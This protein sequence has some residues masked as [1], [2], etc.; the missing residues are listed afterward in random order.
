MLLSALGIRTIER[1]STSV[2]RAFLSCDHP[3]VSLGWSHYSSIMYDSVVTRQQ[4][5]QPFPPDSPMARRLKN[6]ERDT[7][8]TW[9][10]ATSNKDSPENTAHNKNFAPLQ[11]SLHSAPLRAALLT[12]SGSQRAIN[13][14]TPLRSAP[15]ISP[16][17][18]TTGSRKCSSTTA[19]SEKNRD[20]DSN[21][22]VASDSTEK[23][24]SEI[25]TKR[26]KAKAHAATTER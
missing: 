20:E 17:R 8:A 25:E 11:T 14:R 13:T 1:L 5:I 18:N 12:G 2:S 21:K 16:L 7:L 19:N 9:T 15:N 3:S 4:E 22:G 6:K 10:A 26:N 23:G 24:N